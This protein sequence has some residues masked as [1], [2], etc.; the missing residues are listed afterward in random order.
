MILN[1]FNP[2][3]EFSYETEVN[4]KLLLREGQNIITTVYRKVTNSDIYLNWDSF[5]PHRWK[6]GTLKS[7]VQRAHLI[8]STEDLLKTELNYMQK[9][10][11]EMN[12]FPL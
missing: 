2:S 5:C 6:R 7:L 9:V 10:F 4:S 8:C 12:D 3:I 11:L 1:S